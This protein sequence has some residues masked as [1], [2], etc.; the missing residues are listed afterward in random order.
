[1]DK[2]FFV[3]EVFELN[4]LKVCVIDSGIEERYFLLKLVID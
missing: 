2:F 3:L 4:V 1:M